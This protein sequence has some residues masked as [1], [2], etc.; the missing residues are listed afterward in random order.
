MKQELAAVIEILN[1]SQQLLVTKRRGRTGA[2]P[3][4]LDTAYDQ[5]ELIH[6]LIRVPERSLWSAE[7][8]VLPGQTPDTPPK[9]QFGI[10][11]SS[12]TYVKLKDRKLANMWTTL[13]SKTG[14]V[15]LHIGTELQISGCWKIQH[16]CPLCLDFVAPSP[17]LISWP[18]SSIFSISL[19]N[20]KAITPLALLC[21]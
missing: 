21:T 6:N 14:V 16:I 5:R 15:L 19:L 13:F 1:E 9:V 11:Q 8:W 7:K 4:V 17:P 18:K 2:V 12:N 10:L 20:V 3:L